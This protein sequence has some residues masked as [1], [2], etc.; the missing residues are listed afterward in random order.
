MSIERA[1]I[2]RSQP[3]AVAA[4]AKE[5]L[6]Q[7]ASKGCTSELSSTPV[8]LEPAFVP[9]REWANN[10]QNT[11]FIFN[12]PWQ[13][14]D[15]ERLHCWMSPEHTLQWFRAERFVK[16]LLGVSHR[17]GFEITGNQSG[18]IIRLLVHKNDLNLIKVAFDGECPECKITI[19]NT[20][21]N[22][23]ENIFFYD[24]FPPPPYHHLLTQSPELNTSPYEPFIH[25]L[26]KLPGPARGFVQVLFE[27]VKHDWHHNVEVLTDIEFLGKTTADT[28][29]PYRVQQ[30]LPSGDIRNMARE[31]ETKAHNDK[32]F[33]FTAL[34]TGILTPEKACNPWALTAFASLFQ[35]GGKPLEY[36]TKKEYYKHLN[37]KQIKEM[38]S[39]GLSYK[40]GF[41]LNSSELAG[42]VHLP[43]STSF[44]DQEIPVELL[45][46]LS[47]P[48]EHEHLDSGIEIGTCF[49]AGIEKPV[50]INNT[51]RKRSTHL[52]GK[53]GTGKTTTKE[54]L[55]LQDINNNQGL[56]LID[57][58][59]DLVKRLLHFIPENKIESTVYFDLG[60]PE[61]VPLWNPLKRIPGQ[62]I[63]RTADDL[64]SSIK[65]IIKSH[66]WGD[67]LEHLLRNGFFGLLHLDESTFLDLLILFE[68]SQKKS[69]EKNYLKNKILEAV[70]SEVARMF[71]KRDFDG[72]RRDDFA[73]SHHK[74]SKLLN[75]N[76]TVSLMLT[77]P[78]NYINFNEIMDSGKILLIDLSN[79]SPDTRRILGCFL[80]SFLHN[81]S[82]ARNKLDPENRKPFSIYCDEAHKLTTDT[83]ED[84]ITESRKFGVNLTLAHQ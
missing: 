18:I 48:R 35:H 46:P 45:E 67:R 65:S 83:L 8:R 38:F 32:P 28:R 52:I 61:W 40:P 37:S 57:P 31:V 24:F 47:L 60:D 49:Y 15:L 4:R 71:W 54:H 66:T 1:I 23:K 30:Q 64:V 74:L 63:G 3:Y 43:T 44:D 73:P 19:A 16:E 14:S 26:A 58:H 59:G 11:D 53:S 80:L 56:A 41:L 55:I 62:N 21:S 29:T 33:Y 50:Y 70:D 78:D 5:I 6:I 76:E 79:V 27:P 39:K 2:A 82:L 20:K 13:V 34:R 7:E 77:Q 72:Y 42:L 69:D 22:F 84:I 9:S 81:T 36:I 12:I 17:V 75:A 25:A 10:K 51:L 68:Q